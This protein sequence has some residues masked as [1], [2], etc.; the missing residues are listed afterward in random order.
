MSVIQKSLKTITGKLD[1]ISV[2]QTSITNI[3]KDLWDEDGMDE[4]I[5]YVGQQSEENTSELETLRKEN[6]YLCRELQ[7]L[8]SVVIN[9]DRRL[10]HQDNEVVDL[11]GRSIYI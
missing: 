7:V 2:L 6:M 8:K 10:T 3:K 1:G 11:K 5:K 9:M 4:R